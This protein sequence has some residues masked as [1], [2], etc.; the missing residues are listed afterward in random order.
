MSYCIDLAR[1]TLADYRE[2]LRRQTLLPGRRMLQDRI[3]ERFRALEAQGIST[4]AGLKASLSSP[5]KLTSLAGLTGLPQEYLTLLRRELGSLEQKPVMLSAFAGLDAALLN[6]LEQNGIGSSQ[7][8]WE[9][10]AVCPER[11]TGLC[12]LVRINGVGPAAAAA[13]YDAGYRSAAD[14]AAASAPEMLR[15]VTLANEASGYYRAKLGE[16]DMQFCIDF[17][18]VLLRYS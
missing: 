13:F 9:A 15:R 7:A 18:G 1:L 14:V 11:L 8:C 2:L 12:D 16:K 6:R 3:D 4:V 5:A 17:A 10:G